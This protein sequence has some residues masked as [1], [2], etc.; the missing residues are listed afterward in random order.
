MSPA[1]VA[2]QASMSSS[3][4]RWV[5]ASLRARVRAGGREAVIVSPV[6]VQLGPLHVV[7]GQLDAAAVGVGRA[8]PVAGPAEQLGVGVERL[9]AGQRVRL[10]QW[11]QQV[12]AGG[13]ACA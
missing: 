8:V 5:S 13:R 10:H 12:E 3:R 4:R 1:A 6:S 11:L 9:V 7:G 2:T